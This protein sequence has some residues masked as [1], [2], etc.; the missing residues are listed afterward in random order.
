MAHLLKDIVRLV[1][2]AAIAIIYSL[3]KLI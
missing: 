2:N 1:P 3:R